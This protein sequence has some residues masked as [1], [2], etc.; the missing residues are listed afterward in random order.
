M[1]RVD[2]YMV[3]ASAGPLEINTKKREVTMA[4]PTDLTEM[5]FNPL[6]T[7][8]LIAE[9]KGTSRRRILAKKITAAARAVEVSWRLEKRF[10]FGSGTPPPQPGCLIALE[11]EDRA[12]LSAP[13]ARENQR[14]K[15]QEQACS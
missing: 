2:N 3:F 14:G 13:G 7:V 5:S 1:L 6:T 8:P 12:Q 9:L 4:V 11:R 15:N 10:T